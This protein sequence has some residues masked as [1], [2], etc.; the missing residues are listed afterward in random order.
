MFVAENQMNVIKY[1]RIV[2][3]M[4]KKL[5]CDKGGIQDNVL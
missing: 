1:L 2:Y 5:S 3:F 4:L